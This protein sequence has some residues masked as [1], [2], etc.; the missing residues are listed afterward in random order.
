[1]NITDISIEQITKQYLDYIEA[2]EDMNLDIASEYLVMAAELIEMKS[3]VY[4][5]VK[6]SE[7]EEVEEDPREQLI[8]RLLSSKY[9]VI[10]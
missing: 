5:P 3:K 6:E 1:M 9:L 8:N 4:L 10:S 7:N 2:M